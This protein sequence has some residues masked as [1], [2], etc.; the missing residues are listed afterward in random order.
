VAIQKAATSRR[1]PNREIEEKLEALE[2]GNGTDEINSRGG[3]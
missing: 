1:T 2:N 3:G